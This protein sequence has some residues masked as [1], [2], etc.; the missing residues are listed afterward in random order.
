[1]IFVWGRV[2]TLWE[3]EKMPVTG[4]FSFSTMF[5]KA[6]FTGAV[7]TRDCLG[8]GLIQFQN[9]HLERVLKM[10]L[11]QVFQLSPSQ[12]TRAHII[13]PPTHNKYFRRYTEISLSVRPSMCP[14][15][16][17]SVGLCVR[18]SVCV[19][20]ASFCQHLVTALVELSKQCAQSSPIDF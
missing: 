16:G 8:K 20:N 6:C 7:K 11:F 3:M 19:Q 15:I 14:C 10:T 17:V 9:F 4:I 12:I 1:M 5:S 13:N 2:E 18:M